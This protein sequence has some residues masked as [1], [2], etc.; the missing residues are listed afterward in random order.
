MKVNGNVINWPTRP[1]PIRWSLF[2][3][4][5]SVRPSQKQIRATT[6]TM[7]ENN[8]HQLAGAWWI[9]L[10]SPNYTFFLDTMNK[11]L[12]KVV[13]ALFCLIVIL[14]PVLSRKRRFNRRG[15]RDWRTESCDCQCMHENNDKMLKHSRMKRSISFDDQD[16]MIDITKVKKE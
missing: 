15:W 12:R 9:T 13:L 3:R 1:R 16:L 4:M 7:H 14:T 5:V 8:D 11:F 2:S 6:D 10:K